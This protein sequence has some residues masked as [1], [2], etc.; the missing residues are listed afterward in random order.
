MSKSQVDTAHCTAFQRA[1]RSD[2]TGCAAEVCKRRRA[3]STCLLLNC[4]APGNKAFERFD[5]LWFDMHREFTIPQRGIRTNITF[6]RLKVMFVSDPPFPIPLWGTVINAHFRACTSAP[7]LK[8]PRARE[9]SVRSPREAAQS[10]SAS[11]RER[12]TSPEVRPGPGSEAALSCLGPQPDLGERLP[13]AEPVSR[14][15]S[16]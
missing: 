10:P 8:K 1:L 15:C 9:A 5:M 6:E 16:L 13:S 14:R 12:S 4:S 11:V 2:K 7:A 3:L